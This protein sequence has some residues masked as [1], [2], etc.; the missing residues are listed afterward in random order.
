MTKICMWFTAFWSKI[1]IEITAFQ[2]E[3]LPFIVNFSQKNAPFRNILLLRVRYISKFD[4]A[5]SFRIPNS[6]K[7]R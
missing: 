1:W 3:I 7:F 6:A 4:F 5:M 2:T